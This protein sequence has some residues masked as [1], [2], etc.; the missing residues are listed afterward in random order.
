MDESK[1]SEVKNKTIDMIIERLPK[2]PMVTPLDIALAIGFRT[3]QPVI[4]KIEGGEIEALN[5]GS[6]GRALYFIRRE[7]AINHLKSRA[8]GTG[9]F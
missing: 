9:S 6:P 4:R 1:T 7:A 8:A 3:A 2:S 5:Y